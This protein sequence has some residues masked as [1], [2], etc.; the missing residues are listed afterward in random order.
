VPRNGESNHQFGVYKAVCC[1]A[2]IVVNSGMVFPDCPN[3][4]KLTT[5]WKPVVEETIIS[6]ICSDIEG[7]VANRRLFN[8][9]AGRLNLKAWEANHLHGCKVCQGVL[10][11]LIN[12]AIGAL[13]EN[14]PQS[15]DA[16]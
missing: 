8:L 16:A 5:I 14:P 4:Q 11:V 9:A 7:H 10:Q 13:Q 3:H 12:Q 1:G 2:K 15:S 6:Q